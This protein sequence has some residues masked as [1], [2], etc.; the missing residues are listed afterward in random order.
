M[1]ATEADEGEPTL[2]EE[3]LLKPTQKRFVL[4]PIQD[5]EVRRVNSS[6]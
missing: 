4:Y 1:V 6:E 5:P 3:P 2:Q